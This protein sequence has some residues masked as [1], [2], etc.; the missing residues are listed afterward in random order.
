MSGFIG[1]LFSPLILLGVGFGI[2]VR[3]VF[4]G[5]FL[6]IIDVL[7]SSESWYSTFSLLFIPSPIPPL[8]GWSGGCE[9]VVVCDFNA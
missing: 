6:S 9:V 3:V 8:R 1:V 5:W 2:L 7:T 4:G